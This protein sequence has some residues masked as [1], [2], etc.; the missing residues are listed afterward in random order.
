MGTRAHLP[1]LRLIAC[2]GLLAAGTAA[3]ADEDALT[4][5]DQAPEATRMATDMR[6]FVETALGQS[7]RRDDGTT[8]FERRLSL[9]FDLDKTLAP[10]WRG[11]LSGRYDLSRPQLPGYR[12]GV[13]TMKEAYVSWQ[14]HD[15]LIVDAGRV[16]ARYG[17]AFGYNPTDYL[18]DGAVRSVVS[19][20]PRSLKENRLGSVMLRGQLLWGEGSL[21]ALLSPKLREERSNAGLSADIGATNNRDR[22]L[23]AF[24]QKIAGLTPQWLIHA[25]RGQSP[26][27]GFNMSM[28]P[29]D[30]T[31][32]YVEWSGGRSRSQ[33]AQAL[34]LPGEETF[35]Q[36]AATGFT[37]STASRLSLTV[38]YQYNGAAPDASEWDAFRRGSVPDYWRYR[39]W[40]EDRRDPATR[41]RLLLYAAWQD[42]FVNRLD[43]NA[44]LNR[45]LVDR[46][47]MTWLE[48]R[49]RFD[50]AD[51]GLQW[52][53]N[54]GD[55][56]GEYAA[57]PQRRIWQVVLR[58]YY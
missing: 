18:R 44:M 49:Y 24:S 21:S 46:S 36:R 47:R 37:Y 23:L 12:D 31:V 6:W 7:L 26:Q 40:Q 58:H 39:I 14:V 11:V 35:R 48:V 4:L 2:V 17:V 32:A 34:N 33:L 5:A 25:D 42:V 28:L 16:N 38:E 52:Q 10:A 29:D 19:A 1:F 3:A 30:A 57:A 27:F 51:L 43:V 41:R 20:D 45:S 22:W 8:S 9:A 55:R 53:A 15:A 54:H 50:N 56:G 13:I